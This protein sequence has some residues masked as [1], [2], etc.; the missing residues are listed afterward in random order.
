MGSV[1][2]ALT[3]SK[4]SVVLVSAGPE[5]ERCSC[6]SEPLGASK[7]RSGLLARLP[8]DRDKSQELQREAEALSEVL[9][10]RDAAKGNFLEVPGGSDV[11]NE[12]GD[13]N[14]RPLARFARSKSQNALGNTNTGGVNAKV[15]ERTG[16]ISDPRKPEEILADDLPSVDSPEA[17]EKTA[18]R[19]AGF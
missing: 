3:K 14:S 5:S 10:K 12:T 6:A 15:Q 1:S 13:G 11:A 16:I 8:W 4:K 19:L 2:S 9:N 17:L 18:I 7:R